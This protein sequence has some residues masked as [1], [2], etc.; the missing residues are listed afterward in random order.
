MSDDS[1]YRF[2]RNLG[3]AGLIALILIIAWSLGHTAMLTRDQAYVESV[4]LCGERETGMP[5]ARPASV[6]GQGSG[7]ASAGGKVQQLMKPREYKRTIYRWS[8]TDRKWWQVALEYGWDATRQ[9]PLI[10]RFEYRVSV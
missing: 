5:V 4:K 10:H 9:I 7:W 8:W 6:R 2:L 1:A 3:F